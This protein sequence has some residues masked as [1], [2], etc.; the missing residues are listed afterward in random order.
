[1]NLD[2][3]LRLRNELMNILHAKQEREGA[4]RTL[5]EKIAALREAYGA[6]WVGMNI[7]NLSYPGPETGKLYPV[8][9]DITQPEPAL[10]TSSFKKEPSTS[11][12]GSGTKKE[13]KTSGRKSRWQ[14][15]L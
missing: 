14:R 12:R 4:P 10:G 9:T 6:A 5:R 8:Q 11:N 15:K 1:V 13:P 3:I 2:Q 7:S